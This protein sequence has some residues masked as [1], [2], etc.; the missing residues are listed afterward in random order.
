MDEN[1]IW[2]EIGEIKKG[3]KNLEEHISR[4]DHRING[5]FDTIGEHIKNGTYYRNIIIRNQT[6]IKI[7]YGLFAILTIPV[8]FLC[9][10]ILTK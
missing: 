8:I 6:T 1:K 3:I 10:R 5:T 9:I 2:F 7:I 4:L